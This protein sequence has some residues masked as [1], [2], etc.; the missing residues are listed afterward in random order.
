MTAEILI[1]DDEAAIR[2]TVAD[3]LEDEGFHARRA[4]DGAAALAALNERTPELVLLD[5]WLEGSDLD[6]IGVLDELKRRDPELP[7]IMIS[8]HGTIETAVSA[9]RKGAYDFIEKP[10]KADRLLLAIERAL[11]AARLRREVAELR[12]RAGTEDALIGRSPGINQ[13]RNAIERVAPTNSR[14]LITG[15]AGVGKEIVA[16][17]VHARSRRAQAP[18]L[19]INAA[20]LAPERVAL[21]LFGSEERSGGSPTVY[22]GMHERAHRG[23]LLID[24]VADMPLETQGKLLRVLQEQRFQRVGGQQEVVVDVR[25]LASTH[26]DLE[27]RIAA[28]RFREDLYYRLNV[29]PLQIPPLSQRREDIPI[30]VEHFVG[31]LTQAAG[32]ANRS[33]T[34]EAMA[35]LQAAEW[36]GNVRELKNAI[37]RILILA[38]GD[39][40]T[41]IEVDE[42]PPELVQGANAALD[43]HAADYVTLPLRDARE[44]F[45]RAYLK[46]QLDRFGGNV[47]KTAQFVGMERSALHRKLRSLD[48][49]NG[50]G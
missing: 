5:I 45:E 7:V 15:P 42:L 22:S 26:A 23:T 38:P 2:E 13:I 21:E 29:V 3:T 30:F 36:P 41:P 40:R 34:P 9:I 1:V 8:G 27:H 39:A 25:I 47:S 28:G 48:L 20:T 33:F 43:I 44:R 17:L 49:Q 12:L 24:E 18:F 10:F 16:R 11:E 4:G 32:L 6:G 14:L 37:E 19:V 50:D 31:T 46:A 35:I